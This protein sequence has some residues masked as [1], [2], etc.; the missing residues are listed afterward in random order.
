MDD[1]VFGQNLRKIRLD[2]NKTVSEV[3]EYL[4]SIGCKA[5]T[6]TIYGWERGHSQP[7]ADTIMAMC[8]FYGVKDILG[9][10]GYKK[11]PSADE[12][13]PGDEPVSL[14]EATQLLIALGFIN[15][16]QQLSDDDLAFL[17]N[18]VGLLDAWF[19]KHQ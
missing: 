11:S 16:G 19:S 12:S 9:A 7:T 3:S 18:I 10:F 1:A 14:E 17:T 13:A 15:E 8:D 5:A 2:A 6:Q 4:T